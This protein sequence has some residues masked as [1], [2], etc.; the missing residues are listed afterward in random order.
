MHVDKRILFV[1]YILSFFIYNSSMKQCT[2]IHKSSLNIYSKHKELWSN[3]FFTQGFFSF[4]I[5]TTSYA[6]SEISFSNNQ[7][8]NYV[9]SFLFKN[10]WRQ[11]QKQINVYQRMEKFSSIFVVLSHRSLIIVSHRQAGFWPRAIL[12]TVCLLFCE[13]NI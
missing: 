10:H 5:F 13:L 12:R 3:L 1:L 4:G 2:T 9:E 11:I 7:T 6:F 8:Y